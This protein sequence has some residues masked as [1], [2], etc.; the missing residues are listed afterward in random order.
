MSTELLRQAAAER[1]GARSRPELE[2]AVDL[3]RDGRSA[4]S[5]GAH[6]ATR[7]TPVLHWL[8]LASFTAVPFVAAA[9]GYLSLRASSSA[10]IGDYGLIEALRPGYFV[11]LGMLTLFFVAYVPRARTAPWLGA[12]YVLVF[13]GLVDGA[14]VVIEAGPRF[15]VTYVHVGFADAILRTG[16][17]LPL[18]DARFSWP[19]FF[20]MFGYLTSA[21]GLSD[22]MSLAMWFP[23]VA[24][25]L[26]LAAIW[27]V[28]RWVIRDI[29]ACWLALWLFELIEWSGQYY[30]SP[31]ALGLLMY[32]VLVAV[33]VIAMDPVLEPSGGSRVAVAAALLIYAAVVVS[34]QLTPFMV[35]VVAVLLAALRMT[36]ARSL[37][38]IFG[39]LFVVWFSFGTETYWIGHMNDLFGDAGQVSS[40]LNDNVAERL[41]GNVSHERI[42]Y[43]RMAISLLAW[44]LAGLGVFTAWRRHT[45]D[46][47]IIVLAVAP[48]LSLGLQSYGGEGLI[49]AFLFVL[50]VAAGAAALFFVSIERPQRRRAGYLALGALLVALLPV[51][52]IAKYGNESFESVTAS[53]LRTAS[54]IHHHVREGDLVASI[55]PAGELRSGRVG[56]VDYVPTLDEYEIGNLPS[57]RKAM[58]QYGGNRYLVLSASQYAYV[59]HVSGLPRGWQRDL[60]ADLDASPDFHLVHRDGTSVVYR[61]EGAEDAPAN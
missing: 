23:F 7:K 25:L 24:K 13:T 51:S 14:P 19:G 2:R 41:E 35:I 16:E 12:L 9:L 44:A 29:R 50:P 18:L 39:V 53:E 42:V 59:N 33:L 38:L 21:A 48:L 27:V 5:R 20:S 32:L 31:Q 3:Q 40:T 43:A 34:H 15:P 6:A 47:R 17:T 45:L 1:A 8:V 10:D 28:L 26:W 58:R 55:A 52:L 61:L 22:T 4:A 56:E 36:R 60:L 57:V 11:A 54:W 37:W 46:G 49:R 30:F